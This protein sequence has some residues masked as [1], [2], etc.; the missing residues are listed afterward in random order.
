[1]VCPT[2]AVVAVASAGSGF[3]TST[4]VVGFHSRFALAISPATGSS[5]FSPTNFCLARKTPPSR[6][7]LPSLR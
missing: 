7:M 4:P 6:S 3:L 5:L 1:M 2:T